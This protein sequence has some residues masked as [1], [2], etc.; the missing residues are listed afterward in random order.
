VH[1]P[2]VALVHGP[3]RLVV[4]A[5][6]AASELSIVEHHAR[7]LARPNENRDGRPA[8]EDGDTGLSRDR[9]LSGRHAT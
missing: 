6:K 4:T 1:R 8:V 2:S 5:G 3:H 7:I 9:S